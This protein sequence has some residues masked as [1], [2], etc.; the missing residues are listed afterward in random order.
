METM[1]KMAVIKTI[2]LI[3]KMIK[4]FNYFDMS[5]L[6]NLQK[7]ILQ[8]FKETKYSEN[9]HSAGQNWMSKIPSLSYCNCKVNASKFSILIST[10]SEIKTYQKGMRKTLTVSGSFFTCLGNYYV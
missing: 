6:I 2:I 5:V 8:F 7:A 10:N 3:A 1:P 9:S 4:V